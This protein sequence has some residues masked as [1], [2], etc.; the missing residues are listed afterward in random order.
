[1]PEL[2]RQAGG[3]NHSNRRSASL[4]APGYRDDLEVA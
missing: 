2:H 1:M 3:C 4:V